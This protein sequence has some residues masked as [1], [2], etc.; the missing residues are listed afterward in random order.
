[1]RAGSELVSRTRDGGERVLMLREE[2]KLLGMH[3]VQNVLA[4][5][6]AGLACGA[7]PDSM[8][9][10]IRRFAPVEHRLERVAQI[11]GVTFYNDSKAT[12]VD[13][14]VKALSAF[15]DI[16]G[17]VVLILGGRGKNAP[18]TPLASLIQ[19]YGRA[20][21]LIGEDAERIEEELHFYAPVERARDMRDAVQRAHAAAKP[22]DIVLLA[23]ACASFDMFDS[24][25]H[26]GR[27]FKQ[28]V[29]GLRIAD[30]GLRNENADI[31][32]SSIRNPQ[33]AIRN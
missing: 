1:M 12:N 7:A 30:R 33:S 23:P 9:E 16:K 32:N 17:R 28:E 15:A 10:T 20:L 25:E 4:A 5:L 26:R 24:Y 19:A 14:A 13:A 31:L 3:N 8:R 22:G 29:E 21:I 11:D 18:Y 27:V 2:M 6:A